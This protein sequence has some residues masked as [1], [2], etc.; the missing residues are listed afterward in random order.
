MIDQGTYQPSPFR[1]ATQINARIDHNFNKTRDRIYGSYF[2]THLDN[3]IPA[4]R[5]GLHSTSENHTKT[6]SV[7]ETHMFSSRLLNEAG[8]SAYRVAGTGAKTGPFHLPFLNITGQDTGFGGGWGPA[9]FVQ[10]NYSWRDTLSLI[11]GSHSLKFGFY[12]WRGD[13]DARLFKSVRSRPTFQYNNLLDLV[14]DNP[15]QESGVYFDPVTGKPT[16]GYDWYSIMESLYAQDE[17]KV[18]PNLT[19][20]MGIRWDD[21]GNTYPVHGTGTISSNFVLG[22]GSTIDQQVTNGSVIRFPGTYTHRLNRNF[23]PRVGVAWDPSHTGKW[24]VRGGFGVFRD[25]PTLSQTEGAL[26]TNPLLNLIPTFQAGT[27]NPPLLS[28]GTSDNYPFGFTYP[29]VPPLSLD[30][31]GGNTTLRPQAGGIDRNLTYVPV[32]N[33]MIG[34]EHVLPGDFVVGANYSG[35]FA[36]GETGLGQPGSWQGPDF[37]RF[38]GDLLDGKLDRLNQSF[39]YVGYMSN[40]NDIRYNAMI[41]TARRRAGKHGMFQASYTLSHGTDFGW[42]FPDQHNISQYKADSD[43]DARQRV[44]VIGVYNLPSPSNKGAIKAVLGGWEVT[45][46]SILQSGKPLTVF[47]SAP[48]QPITDSSGNVIGLQP[49]SGDYNA[50]GSNFDYP[51]VPSGLKTS[52]YSRTDFLNGIFTQS[53]FG[54]PTIGTNGDEKRNMFRG[55]GYATVDMA[56]IKNNQLYENLGMQIRVEAFNVLNRVNLNGVNTDLSCGCFGKSANSYNPR[57]FQLGLRL[58]F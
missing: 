36:N 32:Y 22:S 3:E 57:I 43:Q 55:P 28:V 7:N 52:G 35:S 50:D 8:F 9:T 20:T 12:A 4:I 46:T 11:R 34:V 18:R 33:Y 39:G 25:W 19:V 37:N 47:T 44:S 5:E 6:V 31:H 51:N 38:A 58:T 16:G 42:N 24:S 49:G 48:F 40:W 53:S 45:G 29:T 21:Y 27:P 56:F 13:D 30:S 10:H 1:N 41:L 23:S 15:Y 2:R 26:T 14:T 54:V 17:W